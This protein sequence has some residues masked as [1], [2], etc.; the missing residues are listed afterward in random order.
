M[1][2]G[3][4]FLLDGLR[5]RS[6]VGRCVVPVPFEFITDFASVPRLPFVYWTVG[7]RGRGPAV[8]HDWLYQHPAWEDRG[9]ADAIFREALGVDQPDLGFEAEPAWA[10]GAMWGGVRAGGWWAWRKNKARAA[11]LNPEWTAAGWPLAVAA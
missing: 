6:E 11:E 9:L 4:W 7:G 8:V 1:T 2:G 5:Y 3:R 10:R